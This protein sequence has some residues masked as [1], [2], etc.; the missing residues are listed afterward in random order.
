MLESTGKIVEVGNW[1]LESACQQAA[2]WYREGFEFTMA[3]NISPL[4][5]RE[6]DFTRNVIKIIESKNLPPHLIDIEITETMLISDIQQTSRTLNELRDFGTKISVDDF[7][8]GYSSLAYLKDFPIDRLKI[9]RAFIKDFP[10]H[11]DGMIATSIIVLGQSL[12]LEVLAEGVETQEQFTFLKKHLCN[13]YQGHF[14][15]MPIE[16][17]ACL[18]LLR[19]Q[20]VGPQEDQP[21]LITR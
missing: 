20:A 2:M 11:D 6:D 21:A 15:S 19:D 8:T 17:K 9:D 16:P 14:F 7:G 12:D 13:S 4:Q 18:Q 1:I 10:C 5:F 3:I